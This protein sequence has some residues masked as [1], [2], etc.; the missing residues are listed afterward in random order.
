M[1]KEFSLSRNQV[2]KLLDSLGLGPAER[3]KEKEK[4][5]FQRKLTI[6]LRFQQLKNYQKLAK[7]FGISVGTAWNAVLEIYFSLPPEERG[8]IYQSSLY[9]RCQKVLV[10]RQ[11]KY[12]PSCKKIAQREYVKNRYLKKKDLK[13]VVRI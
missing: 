11:T 4:G 10:E 12:C 9:K 6:Y 8:T 2:L 5:R 1:V 7:E 3:E 13:E